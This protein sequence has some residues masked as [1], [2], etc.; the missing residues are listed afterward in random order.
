[1][2][3]SGH[4]CLFPS[5]TTYYTN[6]TNPIPEHDRWEGTSWSD[7]RARDRYYELLTPQ[8]KSLFPDHEIV[9]PQYGCHWHMSDAP[10][11]TFRPQA[12]ARLPPVDVVLGARNRSFDTT[13][14]WPYWDGLL[15]NLRSAG[16]TTGIAGSMDATLTVGADAYAW[17]HPDGDTAGSV[18]LL[19]RC[20]LYVGVDS[21]MS[22]LAG[23][24]SVPMLIID[25]YVSHHMIG[26]ALRA[27]K[28]VHRTIPPDHWNDLKSVTSAVYE[29]LDV[30]DAWHARPIVEYEIE[31]GDDLESSV[32]GI[33][34][35]VPA[36]ARAV[37]R[38]T[39][40]HE[41]HFEKLHRFRDMFTRIDAYR[42]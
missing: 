2:Q 26:P 28:S 39:K 29:M 11:F 1:M 18:D 6:W 19:S 16:L 34:R 9:A 25:A 42:Q 38:V 37:L 7:P 24:M 4:E 12:T 32:E 5:A 41:Q 27:N 31:A 21:G 35:A 15:A 36:G 14:N 40:C 17:D 33:F 22:H 20:R 13:R 30:A 8:L 10:G 3:K 23:V